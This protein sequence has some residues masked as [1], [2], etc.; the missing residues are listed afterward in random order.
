MNWRP[1]VA[2]L[3]AI[4]LGLGILIACFLPATAIVVIIS[5]AIIAVGCWC[6]KC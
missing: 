3:S 5:I 4:F 6:L 2:A 1:R